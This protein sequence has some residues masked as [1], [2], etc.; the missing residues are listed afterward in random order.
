MAKKVMEE[1]TRLGE[2]HFGIG[3]TRRNLATATVLLTYRPNQIS[4]LMEL[5]RLAG[6]YEDISLK[7]L[8]E[9]EEDFGIG[10]ISEEG[11]EV[12]ENE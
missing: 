1:R 8:D 5:N 12:P 6:Q 3:L 7:V 9:Y 4:R 11:P 10:E 2:T